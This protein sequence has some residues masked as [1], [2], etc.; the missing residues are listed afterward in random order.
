MQEALPDVVAWEACKENSQPIRQGRRAAALKSIDVADQT[1][2]DERSAKRK[3][4]EES[5]RAMAQG[6]DPLATWVGYIKWTQEAFVT[7]G[8][9]ARLLQL[10]EDCAYGLKDDTRYADD[11]RYLRIWIQYAD[12]VRDPEQIFD[13]L[14]DRHIGQNYALFW[15]AWASVLE[16]KRKYSSADKAYERGL[17][18]KAKPLDRLQ[19][20]HLKFQHRQVKILT[21][22]PPPGEAADADA[23]AGA[24]RK[25]RKALNRLT[26]KEGASNSRPTTQRPAAPLKP[27]NLA[28]GAKPP[29]PPPDTIAGNFQVYID[30]GGG[31][32]EVDENGVSRA[33]ESGTLTQQVKENT[34]AA[35]AWD[36]VTLPQKKVAGAPSGPEEPRECPFDVHFDVGL[37]E[38]DGVE[39]GTAE[40][41]CPNVRLQLDAPERAERKH[42][43]D[44]LNNPLSRFAAGRAGAGATGAAAPPPPDEEAGGAAA[45]APAAPAAALAAAKPTEALGYLPEMLRHAGEEVC[46]EEQRER[47]RHSAAALRAAAEREAA[48]EERVVEEE[49]VAEEERAAEAREAEEEEAARAVAAEAQDEVAARAVEHARLAGEAAEEAA[50]VE[51]AAAEVAEAEAAEAAAAEAVE[52]E[53]AA[54]AKE[55]AD[56]EAA[57][58]AATEAAAA[59]AA[60]EEAAAAEASAAVDAAA[61]EAAD[62]EALEAKEAAEDAAAVEAAALKAAD[63]EALEAKEAAEAAAAVEAA[64]LRAATTEAAEAEAT[65]AEAAEVEAAAA[66]A[67]AAEV[68]WAAHR[69]ETAAAAAQARADEDHVHPNARAC[70]GHGLYDDGDGL[71]VRLA[72]VANDDGLTINTKAA[73]EMLMPSFSSGLDDAE[74]DEDRDDRADQPLFT[75]CSA[76]KT[77]AATM[78]TPRPAPRPSPSRSGSLPGSAGFRHTPAP[79]AS[80]NLL[81]DTP[82]ARGSR[83]GGTPKP[84]AQR[85]LLDATPSN[86]TALRSLLDST[87]LPL[88][89]RCL[90]EST[91]AGLAPRNL[92]GDT[93][94]PPLG[95]ALRP[96]GAYVAPTAGVPRMGAPL[97]PEV[98]PPRA[99]AAPA[100]AEV[101]GEAEDAD[102]DEVYIYIYVCVCSSKYICIYISIHGKR[103]I[104]YRMRCSK[105]ASAARP[106]LRSCSKEALSSSN[107][108][109]DWGSG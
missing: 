79:L 43:E 19:R 18:L 44:L 83:V 34:A 94:R 89:P 84:L 87:P 61:L 92:L 91:P 23:A 63:A 12:L 26:K 69:V 9:D 16:V 59:E 72:R 86:P 11:V 97:E 101:V 96:H 49:R 103:S 42:A 60:E 38:V 67:E 41:A 70:G 109:T 37:A 22:G 53:E 28:K 3:E 48:E 31:G 8:K 52:E 106:S 81:G 65:K 27:T 7:G 51:A 73:L 32:E 82:V 47:L 13:Y 80:R 71:T 35:T 68:A 66:E 76:K 2:A 57:E 15:E 90:L 77:A 85:S 75:F 105:S 50:A 39:G 10:L 24:Q 102:P 5:L 17:L 25:E 95:A 99:P 56:L 104:P 108:S 21:S 93:P 62:A 36:G 58:A 14:Y 45:A 55:A 54:A 4:W 40:G 64:A 6:A 107:E 100:P 30:D 74:A 98:A 20:S 1:A 33:W 78:C 29:P 46:F 88:A